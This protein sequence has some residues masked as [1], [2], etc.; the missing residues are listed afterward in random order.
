MVEDVLN[1]LLNPLAIAGK[2]LEVGE[3][4]REVLQAQAVMLRAMADYS[5][6]VRALHEVMSSAPSGPARGAKRP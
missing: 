4:Y 6:K 5:D 1:L 2:S 3:A